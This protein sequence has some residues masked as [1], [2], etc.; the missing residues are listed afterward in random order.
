MNRRLSW[1][2][3]LLCVG[4]LA[5]AL[6]A[7]AI[8]LTKDLVVHRMDNGLT[9][10]I[11]PRPDTAP[12]FSGVVSI[13]TAGS[14]EQYGETGIAHMFEHMAFKGS[15]R[16]GTRDY[17]AERPIMEAMDRLAE[18]ARAIYSGHN[19]DTARLAEIRDEIRALQAE[20]S[21]YIIKDEFDSIL[22]RNGA[23]GVNA[24]TGA[25]FTTYYISLP[26]NRLELFFWLEGDRLRY[27]VMREFYSE[28]DVVIEERRQRT[29]DNAFGR[30]YEAFVT[31][32]FQAHPYGRPVIGWMS[33]IQHLT[34]PMAEDFRR[35]FYGPKSVVIAV[36]GNV[37]VQETIRL[38]DKYLA[39]WDA[40]GKPVRVLT[41]EPGF[42]G[43]RRVNV[44]FDAEPSMMIGWPKPTYPHPDAAAFDV[45]NE[46]LSGGRTGRLYRSLVVEQGLATSASAGAGPGDKYD[47]LFYVFASPRAP[48]TLEDV[49]AA[50]Y[51]VIES[52]V[53]EGVSEREIQRARNQIEAQYLRTL[54]SNMSFARNLAGT[55]N[56]WKD[57]YAIN[58]E[59]EMLLAVTAEDV[60]RVAREYL[61]QSRRTVA[62]LRRPTTPA[63]DA[64]A[65]ASEVAP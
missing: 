34:R 10:L 54:R 25:D 5:T 56:L 18:E 61:T 33:D 19:P 53:N 28:R 57:P 64:S 36:V 40:P 20:Q 15:A 17:E 7:H 63:A 35:R 41:R 12:V 45:L 11:Y 23:T 49:E 29:D 27:P 52:I 62:T 39:G 48:S 32:A 58:R 43:E 26:A 3:A 16:I 60:Q 1:T 51:R 13:D 4:L 31:T 2:S 44:E 9:L 8:D 24:S 22:Q 50:T 59:Q 65:G 21:K 37:D 55:T 47:N 42:A 6:C 38:A 14:D 46:V 30:L